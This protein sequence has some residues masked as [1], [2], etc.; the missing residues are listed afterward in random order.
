MEHPSPNPTTTTT[1]HLFPHLPFEL[2]AEIWRFTA[3]P[4]TVEVRITNKITGLTPIPAPLHT[5]SE[6]RNALTRGSHPVYQREFSACLPRE[7]ESPGQVHGW[8]RHVDY[9]RYMWVSWELDSFSIGKSD[10]KRF[11]PYR[12]RF[13]TL[14]LTFGW[15]DDVEGRGLNPSQRTGTYLR[16]MRRYF[17]NL[18]EVY[19]ACEGGVGGNGTCLGIDAENGGD[20]VRRDRWDE[21][22]DQW[23]EERRTYPDKIIKTGR[24]CLWRPRRLDSSV[25]PMMSWAAY[26]ILARRQATKA[27][28]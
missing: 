24:S 8:G 15:E 10:L 16:H 12:L 6:A 7:T 4:R 1:F 13:K 28:A 5:C 25:Y 19:V 27:A 9:D 3:S 26:E 11:I 14:R 23:R 18:R 22:L 21:W 2:G 17:H 20:R